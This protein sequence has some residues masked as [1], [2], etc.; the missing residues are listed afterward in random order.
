MRQRQG[1]KT[2]QRTGAS[3]S[4]PNRLIVRE[5]HCWPFFEKIPSYNIYVL[6]VLYILNRTIFDV[7]Y[8]MGGIFKIWHTM[9]FDCHIENLELHSQRQKCIRGKISSLFLKYTK[10]PFSR[11]LDVSEEYLYDVHAI[12]R[13]S[14]KR[15]EGFLWTFITGISLTK[16]K[17]TTIFQVLR[18]G[19]KIK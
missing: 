19:I 6:S 3:P 7:T 2:M 12:C 15:F 10:M 13:F 16:K 8:C 5:R 17:P 1:E 18:N 9:S 14:S 4:R 11:W